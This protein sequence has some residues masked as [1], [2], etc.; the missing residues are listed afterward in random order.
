MVNSVVNL[1]FLDP[2]FAK[3]L[4]FDIE[5]LYKVQDKTTATA[6]IKAE[7]IG[8]VDGDDLEKEEELSINDVNDNDYLSSDDRKKLIGNDN[9]AAMTIN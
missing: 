8:F 3:K 6:S 7:A 5:Y 9:G 2:E 1:A 4:V